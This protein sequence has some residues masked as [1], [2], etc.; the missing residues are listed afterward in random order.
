[1]SIGEKFATKNEVEVLRRK[2]QLALSGATIVQIE[3]EETGVA[4]FT[5]LADVPPTYAAAGNFAVRVKSTVDELEFAEI[6]GTANQISITHNAANV[7]IAAIP[8]FILSDASAAPYIKLVNAS[9]TARDPVFQWAVG[10][11]PVT[12]F[13]MGVDDSDGDKWKVSAGSA[14]GTTGLLTITSDGF[15]GISNSSPEGFLHVTSP[16]GASTSDMIF[17]D[18]NANRAVQLVLRNTVRTWTI[19][20]DASPDRFGIHDSTASK[21]VI[22]I[23]GGSGNIGL[24]WEDVSAWVGAYGGSFSFGTNAAN[25]IGMKTNSTFPT[26]VP[27][28]VVEFGPAS[29]SAGTSLAIKSGTISSHVGGSHLFINDTTNANQTIGLTITTTALDEIISLKLAGLAHGMTT[30]TETDTFGDIRENSSASNGGIEINGYTKGSVA[31]GLYGFS[32]AGDT[33]TGDLAFGALTFYALKKSGTAAADFLATENVVVIKPH[34]GG[35][36]CGVWGCRANGDT[37]QSGVITAP[38]LNLSATSNQIVLQSAG[39]TGTITATPASSNKVWTLQD[40]T[41]TIYQTGGTDVAVADGGTGVSTFAL[42]GVLFGN[43]ANAIGVTAIGAE[44]QFLRVG[45]NPFVPAWSTLTLPNTGTAYRLPVFSATNVMTELAAVGATGQYLAGNTGAIPSWAN[46]S[47]FEPALGNPGT[48]GW[49]LSSTDGGVRSWI[50]AGGG[51]T[52]LSLT[53]VDEPNYTG[54]AG[55]FVVV[56]GDEDALIFSASSVAAHD[57]LSVTHGDTLASAVSVGSMIF[58]NATPKWAELNA[59]TEGQIL[60]MGATLPGWGRTITISDSAASGGSNGDIW[61]EY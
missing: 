33:A 56:N 21:N 44:G 29:T 47:A 54:H 61:L 45:A 4:N 1:M 25:L 59:G 37:W 32:T 26:T 23:E 22:F 60:E 14:L 28:G 7:T 20:S 31:I 12:K 10:A 36:L 50:A 6:L 51:G 41:G 15:V 40:V 5:D 55:H 2:L 16:L 17:E 43:A 48:T 3:S 42:N 8:Q 53:D 46:I 39:V 35:D 19:A 9:D 49:V 27:S 18:L 30:Y 11:T 52:F 58:G 13:T 24:V 57:V 34:Y 38:T